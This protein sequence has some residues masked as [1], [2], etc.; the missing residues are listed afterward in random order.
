MSETA[1]KV[2]VLAGFF[3]VC[4]SNQEEA[5]TSTLH[6]P[7]ARWPPSSVG[8]DWGQL[9]YGVLDG[10]TTGGSYHSS[11]HYLTAAQWPVL[12]EAASQ[13]YIGS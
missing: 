11:R 2:A 1:S 3:C 12:A 6:A 7:S 8:A 4:R 5:I 9:A 13:D 10:G